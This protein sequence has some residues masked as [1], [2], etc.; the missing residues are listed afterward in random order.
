[1][2]LEEQVERIKN[3]IHC[4]WQELSALNTLRETRKDTYLETEINKIKK[5]I[6]AKQDLVKTMALDYKI[7]M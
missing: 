3:D 2:K 1:M 7:G 5:L 4:H 6:K